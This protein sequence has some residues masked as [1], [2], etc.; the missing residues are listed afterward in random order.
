VKVPKIDFEELTTLGVA[1]RIEWDGG[2]GARHARRDLRIQ[3]GRRG[4]HLWVGDG[5]FTITAGGG[6]CNDRGEIA[7]SRCSSQ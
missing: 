5:T 4:R 3:R 6:A 7:S 1:D 2:N